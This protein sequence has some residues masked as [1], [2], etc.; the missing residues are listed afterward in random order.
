MTRYVHD[1]IAKPTRTPVRRVEDCAIP[2]KSTR[3]V[4][5]TGGRFNRATPVVS[6]YVETTPATPVDIPANV[7]RAD[8]L[9]PYSEIRGKL[10]A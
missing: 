6:R 10:F 4:K 2:R 8:G 5:L 7:Y 1:S 9:G 3:G